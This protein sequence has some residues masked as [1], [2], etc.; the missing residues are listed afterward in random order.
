MPA[1]APCN[2]ELRVSGLVTTSPTLNQLRRLC[3]ATLPVAA[4][5]ACAPPADPLG[6]DDGFDIGEHPVGFRTLELTRDGTDGLPRRLTLSIWYPASPAH[7]ES[8]RVTVEDLFRA[9][10]DEGQLDEARGLGIE[11]AFASAM[12][13]DS[14][15]IPVD[16]ARTALDAPV[17]ARRDAPPAVGRY[18]LALWSVRHATV[19]A[20]APMAE[21][22]ASH[23]IVVATVWSSDPPLAFLWEDHPPAEKVATIE[24]HARDLEHSLTVLRRDASVDGDRIVLLSWS[25]GGQT[26]ARLQE[27]DDAVRAV[28]SLDANVVPARPE[29]TLA[30]RRPL[31]YFIGQDTTG[32]GF[33][34]M[35]TLP[36]PWIT[37]RVPQLAH[38]NFNALEGYLPARLEADTV[39]PWSLGGEVALVGYEALVRMVTTTVSAFTVDRTPAMRDLADHLSGAAGNLS[40]EVRHRND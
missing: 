7:V 21:V 25:Y 36:G 6:W 34:N 22:L 11:R 31:V 23:G 28:I 19:L 27:R 32:R 18:P 40:V 3:W 1:Q 29:E 5:L 8:A 14:T 10:L 4:V 12:T 16:R 9:V 38:G 26:A 35:G 37:I 13:G 24:T 39:F 30:L 20:Q 17:L 15:A 2:R 33:A